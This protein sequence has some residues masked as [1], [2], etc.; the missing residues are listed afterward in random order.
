MALGSAY[1]ECIKDSQTKEEIFKQ[2]NQSDN[3]VDFMFGTKDLEVVG[4]KDGIEEIIMQDGNFI[5]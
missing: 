4:I 1:L 5:K 3:H 2:I